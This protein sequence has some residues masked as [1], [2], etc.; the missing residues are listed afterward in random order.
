MPFSG[1]VRGLALSP[2]K[3][4]TSAV[5]RHL[6]LSRPNRTI[7][8]L[9]WSQNSRLLTAS[10]DAGTKPKPA[11]RSTVTE[12]AREPLSQPP[13]PPPPPPPAIP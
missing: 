11:G 2:S 6:H 5:L 9:R 4:S 10:P 13:P 8:T 12:R 7:A 1:I 3:L